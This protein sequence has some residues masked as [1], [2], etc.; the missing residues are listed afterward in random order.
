M[1]KK[2]DNGN[3]IKISVC[4]ATFNGKRFLSAQINSVL[5]DLRLEDELVIV[6][7]ASED[8]TL[9]I[10]QG[11]NDPRI[12][13]IQNL[14][15]IGVLKSFEKAVVNSKGKVIFFCDQDDLWYKGKRDTMVN[16]VMNPG[17]LAAVCDCNLIDVKGSVTIKSF[18]EIRFSRQGFWKNLYKNTFL[19]CGMCFRRELVSA[20]LPFPSYVSMHDEWVGL[21][22]NVFGLVKFVKEP[23]FGYRRHGNNVTTMQ[24][25][26]FIFAI[27]KRLLNLLAIT[28]R[29]PKALRAWNASK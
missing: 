3:N 10:I 1:A 28:L 29:L 23:L 7:D 13:C 4:M 27:K 2:L 19:G 25:N 16:A 12:R 22:A 24:W 15:N 8:S 9:Q 18:F 6:D 11:F 14:K 20:L 26:G 5:E 17:I 21:M